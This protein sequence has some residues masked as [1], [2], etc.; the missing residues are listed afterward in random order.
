MAVNECCTL[1]YTVIRKSFSTGPFPFLELRNGTKA[2][3][4]ISCLQSGTIGNP[5]AVMLSH[6]NVVHDARSIQL[7]YSLEEGNTVLVSYLP[8][9]HVAAQVNI[10]RLFFHIQLTEVILYIS[11]I[12]DN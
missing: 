8:L 6:D 3:Y 12:S 2:K 10:A 9:S 11:F 5:K 1:V 4:L 7:T